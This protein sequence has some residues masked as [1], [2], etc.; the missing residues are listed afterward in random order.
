MFTIVGFLWRIVPFIIWNDLYFFWLVLGGSLFCQ[1]WVYL[2]QL[3]FWISLLAITVF[4]LSFWF[5]VC[6]CML[7][8]FLICNKC[9]Q[10][11]FQFNLS[12]YHLIGKLI[13]LTFWVIIQNSKIIS[14]ILSFLKYLIL[15]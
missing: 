14:V 5:C 8:T 10:L 2:L 15:P 9:L 1:L 12:I 11:V 3:A 6:F 4:I 13:S 7:G